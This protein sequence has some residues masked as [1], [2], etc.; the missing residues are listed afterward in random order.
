MTT[1]YEE[2]ALADMEWDED[3]QAFTFECPCGDVFQITGD[4][5]AAGEDIAHCPSCSLVIRVLLDAQEF[6]AS[7]AERSKQRPQQPQPQAAA[8]AAPVAVT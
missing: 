6:A 2:V 4:E 1:P 3:L 8:S 7:W 5:L